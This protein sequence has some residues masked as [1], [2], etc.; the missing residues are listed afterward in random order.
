MALELRLD[1][2]EPW[3]NSSALAN[4][5]T[6]LRVSLGD[7]SPSSPHLR[8][9]RS[10]GHIG[11]RDTAW[12]LWAPRC[13]LRQCSLK[14]HERNPELSNHSILIGWSRS[15][16]HDPAFMAAGN[17][18][19]WLPCSVT[20]PPLSRFHTA[21]CCKQENPGV[22]A[23]GLPLFTRKNQFQ[24]SLGFEEENPK[25]ME[26]LRAFTRRP[27][28]DRMNCRRCDQSTPVHSLLDI[29]IWGGHRNGHLNQGDCITSRVYSPVRVKRSGIELMRM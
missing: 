11:E 19:G 27:T 26:D 14:I 21:S 4:R 1:G 8:L 24:N 18:E 23:P 5:S 17:R 15:S 20:S 25:S 2:S 16:T 7:N 6:R 13:L 12:K 9:A 22:T 28:T 10:S 3:L 29:P